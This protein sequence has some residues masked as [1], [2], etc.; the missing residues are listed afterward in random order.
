MCLLD[1]FEE[2]RSTKKYRYS[3]GLNINVLDRM[4][5]EFTSKGV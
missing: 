3:L 1:L 5:L 4:K 2:I